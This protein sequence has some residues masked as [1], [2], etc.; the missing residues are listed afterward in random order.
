M[1]ILYASS[2]GLCAFPGCK[3]QLVH[4]ASGALLGVLCHI[5][6]VSAGGPRFEPTQSDDARNDEGNLILLCPSHHSLV[7]QDPQKYTAQFLRDIKRQHES[8]VAKL[9]TSV[10]VDLTDKQATDLSRQIDDESIDF[11]VIVALKKE[12]AA[13]RHYFPELVQ[14]TPSSS[15]SRSYYRGTIRTDRGGSYRVVVT[16]LHSMGNLEA[17]HATSDLIR[18]WNPRFVIVN[19]I[20]GGISREHQ[21]FGDIV[22]S[23]SILYYE[24]AKIRPNAQ[25]RRSRQFQADPSLLDGVLNLT[26]STWRTL[27]PPRPDGTFVSA[28]Q[29]KIHVGAIASGEKVIAA[30]HA[31]DDLRSLQRDLVAIE[32]ESAG[33]ASAAFSAVKKIGFLAIRSICDFADAGKDD[34]WQGYAAHSA[35]SFLRSFIESRP[36]PLSEGKW[37]KRAALAVTP[38]LMMS[39]S[40]RKRLFDQLCAAFDMEEFKNLCFLLGVDIDE[41]PGD[42]KSARARELILLFERRDN[43]DVLE[44]AVFENDG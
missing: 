8:R 21:G 44:E 40:R 15:S 11:A 26:A 27:L 41:V 18:E 31:V 33:V 34:R 20:A 38:G 36:V 42:R 6:A 39:R 12:L 24:L 25:E 29:P 1:K 2:G 43:L 4:P 10:A 30:S 17:A 5:H 22:V 16:L 35:A 28:L 9:L 23:S 3:T 7:D 14:I 13:V 19:G 37:P 32:M